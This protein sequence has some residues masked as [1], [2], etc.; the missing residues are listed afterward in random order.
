MANS[1]EWNT[2]EDTIKSKKNAL[3]VLYGMPKDTSQAEVLLNSG[4]V[5]L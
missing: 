4:K 3:H 2:M 1:F 5:E